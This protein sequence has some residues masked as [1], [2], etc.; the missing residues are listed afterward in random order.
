MASNGDA[1][2]VTTFSDSNL[3]RLLA[4]SCAESGTIK[5]W[6]ANN[7]ASALRTLAFTDRYL[8]IHALA[9]SPDGSHLAGASWGKILV[10]KISEDGR[11]CE[12]TDSWYSPGLARYDGE[13]RWTVEEERSSMNG[14]SRELYH[15]DP[16]QMLSYNSDGT[17]MAYAVGHHVS[18][19]PSCC[20]QSLWWIAVYLTDTLSGNI[21]RHHPDHLG[22]VGLSEWFN[23][24]TVLD[25][26]G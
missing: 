4:T 18:H 6:D 12:T 14:A 13:S 7:P 10:W 22:V 20:H 25:L 17:R 9:F 24:S 21:D 26:S 5:V 16:Q 1:N 3:P 19:I 2:D 8:P 15:Q 11:S 23:H